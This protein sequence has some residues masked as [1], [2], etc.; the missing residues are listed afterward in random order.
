MLRR[1]IQISAWI[2]LAVCL[3]I[4]LL[5]LRSHFCSEELTWSNSAGWRSIGTAAGHLEI[6]LLVTDWSGQPATKFQPLKYERESRVR[7]PI[8]IL[9][10]LCSSVGDE[11]YDFEWGGIFWHAKL[12]FK[13][14]VHHVSAAAPCWLLAFGTMLLPIAATI[15]RLRKRS[16]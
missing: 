11:H 4:H 10:L 1:M 7:P 8:N 13:H 16:S 3:L 6:G 5:W 2:S 12:N 15:V 14:G 9:G